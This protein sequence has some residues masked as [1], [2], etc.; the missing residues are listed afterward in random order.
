MFIRLIRCPI[1]FFDTNPVGRILNRFTSDVA[2][3]DDSLPMTVFEFL[4]CL[5]QILGTI[6]LVGLINLWSFIPAIIASS[7]TLFL[8]Y[9]FASCSRDLKRLVG[10]TRSPVYSQLTSTIH[11]LK[12]IRSYHAENIS[13]KEFHSHLDNNTRVIYLMAILNRWSAMRFDWISLI[14]IALV[15]ILAIIL[16][17]SQHHFSTAEIALTFTYSISL[18]GL[19]QWTI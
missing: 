14:F 5:S 15:I 17:M 1:S 16:R 9:R 13:S 12:V 6:I 18:M 8:R 11:G 19:F 7:G 4:A 3:M 2:T 10:T